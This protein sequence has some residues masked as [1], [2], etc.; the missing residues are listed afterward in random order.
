M[1]ERKV[2]Q[3]TEAFDKAASSD[4]PLEKDVFSRYKESAVAIAS[5]WVRLAEGVDDITKPKNQD[6]AARHKWLMEF[7]G[8]QSSV[9]DAQGGEHKVRDGRQF[10]TPVKFAELS[11]SGKDTSKVWTFNNDDILTMLQ[12]HMVESAKTQVKAEEEAAVKRGFVRQRPQVNAKPAEEPKPVVGV[13][14]SSS[15][16]PGPVSPPSSDDSAHPGKEII[17]ILAL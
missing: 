17:S 8:H 13:R 2:S 4:D 5:D 12:T 16:A 7:I 9:F 1:I 15:A 3:F 6:Q 11:S 10:V 14:A